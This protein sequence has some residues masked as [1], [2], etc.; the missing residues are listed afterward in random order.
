MV[1]EAWYAIGGGP[2][3][4]QCWTKCGGEGGRRTR[5]MQGGAAQD[6]Q[7]TDTGVNGGASVFTVHSPIMSDF[8]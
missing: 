2:P 1:N 4:S 3:N 5:S 8:H 6:V 7:G